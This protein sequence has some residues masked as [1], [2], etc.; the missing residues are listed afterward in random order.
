MMQQDFYQPFTGGLA[1]SLAKSAANVNL[2]QFVSEL[3]SLVIMLPTV[4]KAAAIA[5][6]L[7]ISVMIATS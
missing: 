5:M 7:A 2:I 4:L 1:A 3:N 6:S